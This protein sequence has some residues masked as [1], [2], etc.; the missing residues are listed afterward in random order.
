MLR[1]EA[2][3]DDARGKAPEIGKASEELE[4]PGRSNGLR[5]CQN[6]ANHAILYE[7]L[8]R[9]RGAR[10]ESSALLDSTQVVLCD[11]STHEF[12]RQDIGCCDGVLNGEID[13][14]AADGRHG[15]SR[16]ADAKKSRQEPAGEAVHGYSEEADAVPIVQFADAVAQIG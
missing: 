7:D 2:E 12:C 1:T 13:A 15:M 10:G 14:D 9:L 4:G 6:A 5:T 11:R 3:A 16:V 8:Q